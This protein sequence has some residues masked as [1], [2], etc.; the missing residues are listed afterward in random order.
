MNVEQIKSRAEE[1]RIIHE[2]AVKI[3]EMI[4]DVVE[5]VGNTMDDGDDVE[6]TI[7]ELV[8]D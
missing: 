5:Q 2:C 1:Q 6:E 4:N 8:F 7:R 3:R